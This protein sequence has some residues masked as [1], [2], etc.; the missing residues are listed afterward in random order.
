MKPPRVATSKKYPHR[1]DCDFALAI[2]K[3]LVEHDDGKAYFGS[4]MGYATHEKDA[5]DRGYACIGPKPIERGTVTIQTTR[6]TDA[7]RAIYVELGLGRLPKS[8]RAY[9]WDWDVLDHG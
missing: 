4:L 7:G 3:G 8:G 9:A 5:I 1:R 2:V 6:L